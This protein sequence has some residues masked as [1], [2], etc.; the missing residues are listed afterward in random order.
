MLR[1]AWNASSPVARRTFLRAG[2]LSTL[3]LSLPHLLAA[4]SEA[5]PRTGDAPAKACILLYMLGGPPQQETFDLKPEAPGSARS[6]FKPIAT[7]VPGIEICELLPDLARQADRFAIVR[8]V[9]HG[10]NALFHGAGVH[11]NLTGWPN[12]PREGEPFLDRRDHPSIGAVLNQLEPTRNGLPPSV[13]LPMWITQDGPGREW[14]G[15]H[16]G[17]LGRKCDP[18][19]MD[20]GYMRLDLD[21][22]TAPPQGEASLPGTLPPGFVL[23]EEIGRDRLGKRLELQ[24]VLGRTGVGEGP[25]RW[26]FSAQPQR[27]KPFRSTTNRLRCVPDTATTGW[28]EVAWSPAG[29]SKPGC[30]W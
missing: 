4:R 12:F 1:S 25:R 15:Q 19:V 17:F 28:G 20:Y 10:G 23:R 29:W 30:R 26:T 22:N 16:A 8:S 24:Q 18:H 27:G 21:I 9:F 11:Y 13:Q 7:N 3:G 6:L 2:G 5:T 14:A